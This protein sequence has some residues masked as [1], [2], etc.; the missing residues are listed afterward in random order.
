M[1][2]LDDLRT[3]Q[4]RLLH[5]HGVDAESMFVDVLAVEGPVHVLKTGSGPPVVLVPGFADPAAMWAS[6]LARLDGFALHAVDRP[7]FGLSGSVAHT[8]T[9]FRP[10]AVEFLEQVLDALGLE[11]P[12]FVGNSIGAAWATFFALEHP[13]RAAAL[14]HVGC[15]AFWLGTSAPLPM[16]LMTI[17]LLGR[18]MMELSP[19]SAEQVEAFGR[20]VAGED[21]SQHPELRD[22]LVAA[23]NEPGAQAAIHRL[24]RSV[25][26]VFGAWPEVALEAEE[27]ARVRPPVLL[28]WGTR[29]AFGD[30]AVG[31]EASRLLPDGR[32]HLVDGGGHVPWIGHPDEVAAA[33][34][35]F[36]REHAA[37]STP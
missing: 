13:D 10:L 8:A 20:S 26:N 34:L 22:L 31:E 24:L 1:T 2:G 14:V 5:S 3:A 4:E 11:R 16:R 12:L 32:L 17:P 19:P 23:Q 21:L 15:P 6:L 30:P 7:C 18:F 36:L 29:D 27:I 33:A 37:R 25:L 35:P 9:G 28:I